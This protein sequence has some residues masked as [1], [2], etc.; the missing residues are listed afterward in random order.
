MPAADR[1]R[2]VFRRL[3]P[4]SDA[5]AALLARF[6]TTRDEAAFAALVAR[7][8]PMVLAACRRVLGSPHDAED[9]CQ[10]A[11][12]VLAR[13]AAALRIN[14]SVA[15]WLHGVAR[16]T[17]LAARRSASRRRVHEALAI[18]PGPVPGADGDVAELRAV[19]DQEIARLP[20]KYR[21][22]FVLA[23]LEGRDRRE[24]AADL[25]LPV[26]TVASR[27]ARR[28]P[29]WPPGF[30]VAGGGPPS[31]WRSHRP[32]CPKRW[33]DGRWPW[34]SEAAPLGRQS[35]D[36]NFLLAR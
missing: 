22:V 30:A 35:P 14:G 5:D 23:D 28:G 17:A 3:T 10:A 31:S 29:S 24:V 34:R 11:F 16:R 33:P 4:P 9:A 27:H 7:H 8:G 26:G 12:L 6:A 15:A 20:A 19:L 25:G 1:L 2:Q 32:A 21:A 36:P 18:P 13:R